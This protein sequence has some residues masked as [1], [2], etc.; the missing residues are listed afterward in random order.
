MDGRNRGEEDREEE[1]G[2]KRRRRRKK[3]KDRCLDETFDTFVYQQY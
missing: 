1:S 3:K 2:M